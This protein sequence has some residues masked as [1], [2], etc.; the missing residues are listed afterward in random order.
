MQEM[1]WARRL[2]RMRMR[3]SVSRSVSAEV[4]SSSTRM[5]GRRYRALAIEIICC[6]LVDSRRTAW[7]VAT[8][9]PTWASASR[10]RAWVRFQSMNQGRRRRGSLPRK[11]FSA[12]E[13]SGFRLISW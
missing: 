13:S 4:G 10:A 9:R 3:V 8:S 11:M 7:L 6:W 2:C 12:T 5:R 1:P